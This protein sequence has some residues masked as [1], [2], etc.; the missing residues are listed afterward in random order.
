MPSNSFNFPT[1][2][3]N[4][5]NFTGVP[6]APT[7]TIGTNTTQLATT[8][9]VAAASGGSGWSLTGNAGTNAATNF[10]GT[11]DN[12]DVVFR[13]NNLQAGTIASTNVSYGVG[14]NN[15]ITSAAQCTAIGT[16]ANNLVTTGANN[17]AVGFNAVNK[18]TTAVGNVGIG[19]NCL[20]N[21]TTGANNTAIGTN[22]ASAVSTGSNNIH[23]G[24]TA[25]N[26]AGASSKNIV[27]SSQG[28]TAIAGG[29]TLNL[30]NVLWGTGCTGTGVTAAGAL[31]IGIN[32][33]RASSVLDI[34]SDTKA[35]SIPVLTTAAMT[36]M[37][38][39]T[40][41]IAYNFDT[42]NLCFFNGTAWQKVSH[43]PL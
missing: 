35:I 9:F 28:S 26:S 21:A 24:N 12:I 19:S 25:N 37:L 33:P 18:V 16:G 4:S 39:Y 23:I 27:I 43:S 8:A 10:H 2:P 31:S 17:T 11:T 20:L 13:R 40:G 5:P 14:A 34:T 29:N 32:Q 42:N 7:A 1:A 6:T 15:A 30:G 38:L 3:L 36:S 41:L 22:A